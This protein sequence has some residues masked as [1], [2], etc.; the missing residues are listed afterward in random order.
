MNI[1]DQFSNKV[2]HQILA[3]YSLVCD[4]QFAREYL[5]ELVENNEIDS[6][7][8]FY[9][10]SQLRSRMILSAK[11]NDSITNRN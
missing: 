7:A 8:A 5:I 2:C 11:L 9:H 4:L 3:D 6:H 10:A 1:L